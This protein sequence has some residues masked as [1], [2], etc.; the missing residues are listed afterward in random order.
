LDIP[1]Q[2]DIPL[3]DNSSDDLTDPQ[4]SVEDAAKPQTPNEEVGNRSE[5][6]IPVGSTLQDFTVE[7]TNNT[8]QVDNSV[9]SKVNLAI[10]VDDGENRAQVSCKT[11]P[12]SHV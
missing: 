9:D 11:H 6:A 8:V 5:P 10:V 2:D 4:V 3:V 7:D 12:I 1:D